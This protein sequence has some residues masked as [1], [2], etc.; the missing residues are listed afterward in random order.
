MSVVNVQNLFKMEKG[1]AEYFRL[2]ERLLQQMQRQLGTSIARIDDESIP[3][4]GD[5][6]GAADTAQAAA[7]TAQTAADTAQTAATNAQTAADNAAGS[8]SY[9]ETNS[10]AYWYTDS[11]GTYPASDP[12][13]DITTTFYDQD[14]TSIATRVLRGTLTSSN[15]NITV[16]NVSSSGLA[17]SYVLSGDGSAAVKAT[18]TITLADGSRFRTVVKWGSLDV[19]AG[20]ELSY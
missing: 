19:S 1:S 16:T 15:G 9:A 18:I 14:D 4:I 6:Q 3:E 20:G 8:S 10:P 17:T 5:A 11:A 13:K 7:T 12:T 2:L